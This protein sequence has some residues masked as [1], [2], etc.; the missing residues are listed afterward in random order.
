MSTR[1]CSQLRTAAS[2]RLAVLAAVLFAASQQSARAGCLDWLF[3]RHQTQAAYYPPAYPT[4]TAYGPAGA[5][6]PAASGVVQAQRPAYGYGAAV[7]VQTFDN[8][9][10]YTGLPTGTM[11]S[12]AA[13]VEVQRLPVTSSFSATPGYT[14]TPRYTATPGY[15]ATPNV[16]GG[17]TAYGSVDSYRLP[18]TS[19]NALPIESTLRGN[20]GVNPITSPL[21]SANYPSNVAATTYNAPTT[22]GTTPA[23]LP[24]APAPR[25][26]F[27]SGLR[28]FFNSLLGRDTNYTTSYYTAPITYY[29]PASTVD[30]VTGTTVTVQRPCSSY[31]QQLQRVPYNSFQPT[32][33]SPLPTT[34]VPLPGSSV[35][36][37]VTPDSCSPS[38][39]GNASP[40]PSY[41]PSATPGT[42]APPSGGVGQVGGQYSPE[43]NWVTPIPSTVPNGSANTAPLTGADPSDQQN[44]PQPRLEV[45]SERPELALPP[46]NNPPSS[47]DQ[48]GDDL[49]RYRGDESDR[50]GESQRPPA[51]DAEPQGRDN[52][53]AIRLDPP[54]SQRY[55][56]TP[57]TNPLGSEDRFT[58]NTPPSLET[59]QP[60]SYGPPSSYSTLRPIGVPAQPQPDSIPPFT[61][62]ESDTAPTPSTN[63]FD[64]RTEAAPQPPRLPP[65]SSHPADASGLFRNTER[66]ASR[67]QP[68]DRVTVPVREATTRTGDIRQVAAW[69]ES[70]SPLPPGKPAPS[71]SRRDTGGWLPAN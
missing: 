10:V 51:N 61:N 3:G 25:W 41:P 18:I 68:I 30:P 12:P 45:Q 28:R 71:R 35:P 44:V 23:V 54:V 2:V 60:E 58:E 27:G 70:T 8:P 16:G 33:A 42:F 17:P 49:Y 31:V 15:T 57:Q 56:G 53:P 39:L 9:S 46:E 69:D 64:N 6:V 43:G 62:S 20:A 36:S 4:A 29:R 11:S 32:Q 22:Y 14:A 37:M 67:A 34:A 38:M 13:T 48:Y 21:Y 50:Q 59:S 65:A 52:E 24:V 66:S 63:P 40:Q 5:P 55:R 26:T 7:P 1:P 19:S 47:S